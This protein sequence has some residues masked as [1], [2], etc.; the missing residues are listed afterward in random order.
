MLAPSIID[1]VGPRIQT[2]PVAGL[3]LI[4][5][6]TPRYSK[7]QRLAKRG[8]DLLLAGVGLIVAEPVP[9][10][11]RGGHPR[12]DPRTGASSVRCAWDATA[13]SSGC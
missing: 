7:G 13:A 4:H 6:E 11:H 5:V 1:V 3:P 12:H 8:L 10:D 9:G 2:R